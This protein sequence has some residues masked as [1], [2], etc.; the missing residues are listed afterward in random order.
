M[1]RGRPVCKG[2]AGDPRFS[3][4]AP[5]AE[6]RTPGDM[7]RLSPAQQVVLV[8]SAAFMTATI[9]GVIIFAWWAWGWDMTTDQRLVAVGDGI[10]AGAVVLASLAVLLALSAYLVSYEAVGLDARVQVE[11]PGTA[12]LAAS[13]TLANMSRYGASAP[14]VTVTLIGIGGVSDFQAGWRTLP[15]AGV[16]ISLLWNG[17]RDLTIHPAWDYRLPPIS[18]NGAFGLPNSLPRLR[19]DVVADGFRSS[20]RTVPLHL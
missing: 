16:E 10:A 11:Q 3:Y 14:S 2:I 15:A 13:I 12:D 4:S 5:V 20:T 1:A 9:V 6:Q 19:I 17:G 7:R 8:A 18:L